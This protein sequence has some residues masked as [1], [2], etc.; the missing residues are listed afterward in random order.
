VDQP[1]LT[2]H[3]RLT[4]NGQFARAA[5]LHRDKGEDPELVRVYD[6]IKPNIWTFNGVFRLVDAWQEQAGPRCVF[7]FR[8]EL[9]DHTDAPLGDT[10]KDLEHNRMIPSEVKRAVWARDGGRCVTCGS[11]DNLHFDHVLPYSK[12]G[13][14]LL[15]ENV[16]LLCARHNLEKSDRIE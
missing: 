9:I 13:S 16:Q 6:K 5:R 15:A 11:D 4:Q 1:E 12:G 8:L 7:K 10:P 14:S 3:G 2:P